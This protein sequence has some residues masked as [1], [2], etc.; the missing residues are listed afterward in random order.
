LDALRR[1]K[2]GV[3][4]L[5]GCS[6]SVPTQAWAARVSPGVKLLA[7][8]SSKQLRHCLAGR[9]Q[10]LV[11]QWLLRPAASQCGGLTLFDCCCTYVLYCT[12][13]LLYCYFAVLLRYCTATLLYCYVTVLLLYC[14]ATLMYCY[15][16]VLLLY[17]TATLLTCL[18]GC[19]CRACMTRWT[20]CSPSWSS[21]ARHTG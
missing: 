1:M 13:T 14:T 6:A 8:A 19:C 17:C 12:A 16:T 7:G 21:W 5:W 18:D 10:L 9:C 2:R 20:S 4:G 11:A 3:A 15:F